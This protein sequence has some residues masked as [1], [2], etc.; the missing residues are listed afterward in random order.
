MEW[1]LE[2]HCLDPRRPEP[3]H[4]VES[5]LSKDAD[6]PNYGLAVL[7]LVSEP[8]IDETHQIKPPRQN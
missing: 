6:T 1:N 3:H 2:T 7:R 4:L 8:F 5:S